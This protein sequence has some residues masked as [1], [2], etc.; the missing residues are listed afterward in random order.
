MAKSKEGNGMAKTKQIMDL[1][2]G[3]YRYT[4]VRRNDLTVDQFYVYKHWRDYDL[5][6]HRKL[7]QRYSNVQ[8]CLLYLSDIIGE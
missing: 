6:N 2:T 7:L 3:G 5:G 1:V 8:S 4:V